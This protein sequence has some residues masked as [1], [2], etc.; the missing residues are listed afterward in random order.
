MMTKLTDEQ[1][2]AEAQALDHAYAQAEAFDAKHAP[3]RTVYKIMWD[4]GHDSGVFPQVYATEDEAEAAAE[5]IYRDNIAED[6]WE[7]E[8]CGCEVIEV[9]IPDDEEGHDEMAELHKA[10]LSRGRP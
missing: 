6:V 10:A 7:P 5:A 3:S 4:I 9:E 1:L 2:L 8:E